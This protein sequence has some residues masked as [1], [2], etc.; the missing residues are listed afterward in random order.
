[1]A[2][3]NHVRKKKASSSRPFRKLLFLSLLILGMVS[4]YQF[5]AFSLKSSIQTWLN[6]MTTEARVAAI[7]P[8]FEFYDLLT[9]EQQSSDGSARREPNTVANSV[10]GRV[11]IKAQALVKTKPEIKPERK[12]TPDIAGTYLLQVAS[13]QHLNDADKLKAKLIMQGYEVTIAPF[14]IATHTWYRVKVGPYFNLS[15]AKTARQ[16]VKAQMDLEPMIKRIA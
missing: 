10:K 1:M 9:G 11:N 12:S 16:A 14:K 6:H 7:E 5:D 2:K 8:E 4:I 13:F 3:K 15:E